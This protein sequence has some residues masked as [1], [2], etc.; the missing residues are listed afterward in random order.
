M[1]IVI[2]L[3][4]SDGDKNTFEHE[5]VFFVFCVFFFF[6]TKNE[7][8]PYRLTSCLRETTVGFNAA[9]GHLLDRRPEAS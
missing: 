3:S 2:V 8:R 9:D 5:P 7:L 6:V 1:Y 4:L